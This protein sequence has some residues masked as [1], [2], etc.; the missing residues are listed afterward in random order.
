[1]AIEDGYVIARC[2]QSQPDT[3]TALSTYERLRKPRVSQ[4]QLGARERGKRLHLSDPKAMAERDRQFSADPERRGR[5]MDWIYRYDVVAE[6][7][8]IR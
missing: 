1:M 7:G 2:L 4:V 5:E 3:A 8:L 6:H